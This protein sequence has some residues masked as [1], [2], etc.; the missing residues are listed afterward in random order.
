MTASSEILLIGNYPNDRSESM[1]RFTRCLYDELTAR[2]YNVRKIRPEPKFGRFHPSDHGIGKWFGYLD[3]FA[4][5]PRQLKRECDTTGSRIVHIC[6][7]ANAV[8]TKYLGGIPHLLTCNDLLAIRSALGE[9]PQNRTRWTGRAY[10]KTILNGIR[11]ARQITCISE[12]TRSDVLRV[13]R[14]AP[15]NVDVTYMGLNY[16]FRK[17]DQTDAWEMLKEYFPDP[18]RFVL[19]VGGNQWYK[20]RLGVLKIFAAL[21]SRFLSDLKLV[22]VG[23]P[24]ASE[25]AAFIKRE[26]LQ[27]DVIPITTCNNASLCALYSVAEALLF[28]SLHEGFGWPIIEAQACA[29]PVV[30]SDR[31]P[32]NEIG[33]TASVY[34]NPE[35]PATA[36]AA[37]Q[38]LLASPARER[39]ER[40]SKALQNAERF[41]TK[42]M[43]DRYLEI[44]EEL[45]TPRDSAILAF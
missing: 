36:A 34:I 24:P 1:D 22:L 37:F 32:M 16:P 31:A 17:I 7:Q 21:K 40:A 38:T 33:G 19:H 39:P 6:D 45:L 12:A 13:A 14:V 29:C 25:L 3:K 20:N 27:S 10:Q 35:N 8:Y 43:I 2:D 23:K 42:Q 9:F 15:Q 26:S 28:P 4:V 30:T 11:R 44:Y 5:F 18:F 41:S